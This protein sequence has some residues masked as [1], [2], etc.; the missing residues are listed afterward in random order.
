MA[1][2]E[3]QDATV[4]RVADMLQALRD[5]ESVELGDFSDNASPGTHADEEAALLDDIVQLLR[6]G[7]IRGTIRAMRLGEETAGEQA[8][9]LTGADE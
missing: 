3:K 1:E 4:N 7:N 2:Q 6:E 5:G 8:R 9:R